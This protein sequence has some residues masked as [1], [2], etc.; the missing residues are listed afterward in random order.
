MS[1][2]DRKEE[3]EDMALTVAVIE[4]Q[5]TDHPGYLM[6]TAMAIVDGELKRMALLEDPLEYFMEVGR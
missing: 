3:L 4:A 6:D 2:E 1:A 5:Q